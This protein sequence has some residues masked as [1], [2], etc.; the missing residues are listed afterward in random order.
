MGIYLYTRLSFGKGGLD[1]YD[2]TS[3]KA[4]ECKETSYL[5]RTDGSFYYR[6]FLSCDG[7]SCTQPLVATHPADTSCPP[8]SIT[9]VHLYA[10]QSKRLSL[11]HPLHF[12]GPMDRCHLCSGPS[13]VVISPQETL[14]ASFYNQ[15][16]GHIS[17]PLVIFIFL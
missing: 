17:H 1:H 16:F 9:I 7:G 2:S 11:L 13:V 10:S 12:H 14:R 8:S 4:G 5:F 15:G 3:T 6:C